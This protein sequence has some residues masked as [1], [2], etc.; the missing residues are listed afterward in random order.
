VVDWGLSRERYWGTPLPIWVCDCGNQH[1]VG[2]K[3]ELAE[4]GGL[5]TAP[6]LHKPYVDAVTLKCEKCGKTMKRTSEVIDC[7]YDSGAMPFAQYHYPFENKDVFEK[8]FPASFISEAVDQTRGWF[9]TLLAISTLLFDKPAFNNCIV[10]GLVNDK[11]GVKMSKHKG[12]GIDPWTILDKQGADA[13][14]WYFYTASMPWLPFR[15]S[16]EA[17]V[18]AQR[19]FLGTLWN[20]YSFYVLYA[21]IDKF[22]PG[23]YR[24][25]DCRLSLMDKWVLSGLNSLVNSV[26]KN[27]AEFKIFESA[28]EIAEFTDSLSNWY[29]RRCRERYWESGMEEDKAAA[30][31]TLFTVLKTLSLLAA[32]FIPFMA[33]SIY[34]NIVRSVDKASPQSVHLCDFPSANEKY[35]D[36]ALE[37]GMDLALRAA[38]LGRA[39][40]A[41]ANI[42]NRQPL[43]RML[44]AG[45]QKLSREL[46]EIIKGELNIREIEFVADAGGYFSYE[47]KPQLKTLGPKFGAKLGV[48]REILKSDAEKVI[49]GVKADGYKFEIDGEEVVLTAGDVL[50]SVMNKEGFSAESDGGLTVILDISLTAELVQEGI[51]REIVSKVQNLRKESGFEVTNHIVLS[52]YSEDKEVNKVFGIYREEIMG[53]VLA[54]RLVEL[55]CAELSCG[56]EVGIN[57]KKVWLGVKRIV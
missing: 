11:N 44:L 32:P 29:V 20:T 17:V 34:Q 22:D 21:E 6:E 33:E 28:R 50:I 46:I 42:K 9:Y 45:G 38:A 52:Y 13:I 1:A 15:F 12:N 16:E 10:L 7:W 5:K 48:V 43:A 55:S 35:I 3:K 47:V 53:D 37:K 4:L 40:R 41:S 23:L 31:M 18:E 27:L 14:R 26:D 56:T 24:L 39:A 57:G 36:K 19:K 30:Y 8:T 51:M 49:T 54:D 2:S 25:E